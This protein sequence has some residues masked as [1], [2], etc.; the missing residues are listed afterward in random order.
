MVSTQV[1]PFLDFWSIYEVNSR[2]WDFLK[3]KCDGRTQREESKGEIWLFSNNLLGRRTH[4][5]VAPQTPHHPSWK[6]FILVSRRWPSLLFFLVFFL[7]ST[8]RG[9]L[10]FHLEIR[11]QRKRRSPYTFCQNDKNT[12]R[13][14]GRLAKSEHQW[15]K[16]EE[17]KVFFSLC[18]PARLLVSSFI[19]LLTYM[20]V[21]SSMCPFACS[22]VHLHVRLSIHPF[23]GSPIHLPANPYL[24]PC[25][26]CLSLASFVR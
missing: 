5:K 6:L 17:Q 9:E 10:F 16:L 23:R 12:F 14:G 20:C 4:A 8:E 2:W 1:V 19:H 21:C 24:S 18:F 13:G 22:S 25:F 26:C 11:T 3:H 7:V 15:A